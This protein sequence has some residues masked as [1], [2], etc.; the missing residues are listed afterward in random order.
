[1]LDTILVFIL[2]ILLF[3]FV[4]S[5]AHPKNFPPGPRYPLPI[6]G[7]GYLLSKKLNESLLNLASKYGNIFGMWLFGKRVV[8]I[9]D[10]EVIQTVLN[11]IETSSR[12]SSE[13]AGKNT[14]RFLIGE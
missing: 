8:I 5:F 10:F 11:K 12:E 13:I 6:I 3:K 9:K 7:H 2:V 1:M 14:L 4:R